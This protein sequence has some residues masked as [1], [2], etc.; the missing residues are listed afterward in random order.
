MIY[1]AV[2]IVALAVGPLL[3][4]ASRRALPYLAFLDG[5]VMVAISGLLLVHVIPHAME[6]GGLWVPLF[7]LAGFFVPQLVEHTLERAAS[8]THALTLGLAIVGLI[9]HASLD[10]VALASTGTAEAGGGGGGELAVAIVLHRLPV[11][12][13]I[14]AL[15]LPMWGRRAAAAVLGVIGVATIGGYGLGDSLAWAGDSMWLALFQALVAG[16]LLHVVVHLPA[17]L[18]SP[19]RGTRPGKIAAGAGGLLAIAAVAMFS[20]THLAAYAESAHSFSETFLAISLETAPVLLLAF[21]LAGMMQ[22]VLPRARLSFLSTGRP[23]SEAARG[24]AFGLPLPICSCGV[25]PLYQTLVNQSVPATAAMAFLVATPELGIDAVLISLPLLG[26]ELTVIRVV[27]AAV[28]AFV[29]GW[30]IGRL[31]PRPPAPVKTL[32][33]DTPKSVARRVRDG[34][35]FGLVEIVDHTGPWLLLGIAVASLMEPML[36]GDWLTVLPFGVDVVLFT[37]LGMPTYVCASGATPLAAILIHKGVSPGAAIAFLLAGP[38]TNL[39]TFG[40]LA[41]AHGRRIAMAFAAAMAVLSIAV[42]LAIN[43]ALPGLGGFEL[44]ELTQESPSLLAVVC[45]AALAAIFA[46]SVLRQGP[47]GFLGQVLSPYGDDDDCHDH[48]DHDHGHRH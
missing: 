45:L 11:A 34:L 24:M 36:K 41:R 28:V 21:A 23:S 4:G 25:I 20:H 33:D 29:V 14:W 46:L 32:R 6:S 5:F 27:A 39:T 38:A 7:A 37:L 13:T 26:E 30:G 15:L 44:D 42:G 35:R 22:V 10:G 2:S 9:I 1:V 12:I 16:S 18:S 31:A 3:Y 8:R 17:P 48:D 40:I 43:L 19:T 47:R